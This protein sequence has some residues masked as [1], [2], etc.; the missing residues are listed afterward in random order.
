MMLI[1]LSVQTFAFLPKES[2]RI[3]QTNRLC[4]ETGGGTASYYNL[5]LYYGGEN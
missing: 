2:L 1:D 5:C 3:Q 4:Q